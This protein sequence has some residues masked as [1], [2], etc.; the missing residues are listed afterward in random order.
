MIQKEREERNASR[1]ILWSVEKLDDLVRAC[2][3]ICDLEYSPNPVRI[4]FSRPKAGF[5]YWLRTSSGA[6]LIM[7]MMISEI[8]KKHALPTFRWPYKIFLGSLGVGTPQKK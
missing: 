1:K 4:G 7:M 8:A 3:K 6:M 2:Q 5:Q